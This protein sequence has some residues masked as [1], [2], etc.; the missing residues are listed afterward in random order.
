MGG[1]A[2]SALSGA[3]ASKRRG[4]AEEEYANQQAKFEREQA[5][6]QAEQVLQEADTKFYEDRLTR[7]ASGTAEG[8]EAY[9]GTSAQKVDETNLQRSQKF[10]EEIR[11]RGKMMSDMYRQR[12]FNQRKIGE[13]EAASKIIGGAADIGKTLIKY[14][15]GGD[16]TDV[17]QPKTGKAQTDVEFPKVTREPSS[18]PLYGI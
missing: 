10:A 12:G 2:F 7:A 6:R 16:K 18:N 9:Q 1:T 17:K 15:W 13:A 4:E 3:K 11:Q 5:Y 14:D 8:S